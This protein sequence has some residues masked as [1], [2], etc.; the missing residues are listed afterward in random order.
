[1]DSLNKQPKRKKMD[2]RFG[3]WNFRSMFRTGSLR[4]GGE[5]SKY[6]LDLVGVQ[7]ANIHFSLEGGMRVMNTGFF[8]QERIKLTVKRVEFIS[9][10]MSY[11]IQRGCWCYIIVLNNHASTEDKV[12]DMKD[13][14]YEELEYVFDKFPK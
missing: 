9:D 2:M 8:V 3:T 7:E 11:K 5:I 14:Y 13:R 1:M 10:R 12:D 4:E 6:T